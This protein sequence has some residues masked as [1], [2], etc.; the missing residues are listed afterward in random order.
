MGDDKTAKV[1]AIDKFKL[2][3]KVRFYLNLD[4][5]FIA[6]SFRLKLIFI[7]TLDKSSFSHSFENKK[8]SLLHNLK[9]VCFVSFLGYDNFYF[10][11]IITLFNE[12]L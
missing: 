4:E 9:L 1:G 7:L 10:L 12:S 3:L 8:F 11:D 5:T 6:P 2:L